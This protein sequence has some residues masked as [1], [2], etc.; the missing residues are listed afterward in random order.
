MHLKRLFHIRTALPRCDQLR[1]R[2]LPDGELNEL[3]IG[4]HVRSVQ[5]ESLPGWTRGECT[6]NRASLSGSAWGS[7][8]CGE[9]PT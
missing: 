1:A 4:V 6:R 7:I 5:L 8:V 3:L 9:Q 2:E